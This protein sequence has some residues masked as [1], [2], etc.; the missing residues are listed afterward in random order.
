MGLIGRAVRAAAIVAGI[1]A[2]VDLWQIAFLNPA[3]LR[4][5][6]A[7]WLLFLHFATAFGAAVVPLFVLGRWRGGQA[8]YL[9]LPALIGCGVWLLLQEVGL[10]SL[11]PLSPWRLPVVV[12]ALAAGLAA[13]LVLARVRPRRWAWAASV[14]GLLLA[15]GLVGAVR[16]F[17]LPR[18]DES[19]PDAG[20][21]VTG[22]NVI[23]VLI[24]TLRA[25]H[26]SCYGYERP[27]SPAIDRFAT[28]GVLF[29]RAFSQSTWTKPA[30][31]SLFTGRY[32][33]QH[34]A[35]LE[36]ARLSDTELLLPEAFDQLGYRTAVFSGNPWITPD[37]GFDQGVDDFYS[38]Y[39]ERFARVTLFMMT[40]KRVSNLIDGGRSYNRVKMLVQ[41]ELST[42]ER[43]TRLNQEIDRWLDEHG[44]RPFFMHV[45]Y[46]SPHHPYD[47]PP[48]FDRFVPDP[49][50]EPVTYY[51]RKSYFFFEEGEEISEAQRAD[52]VARYDGDILFVDA[53]FDDLIANLRSRDLLD[54]TVVVLTSDHGEEFFDHRNWG[55]GQS[56][57]NELTHVPLIVRYP[58]RFPAG[59]RVDAPVMLVDVMPTVL[60]LAGASTPEGLAGRSLLALVAPRGTPE[61]R[62]AYSELLYRYGQAQALVQGDA[63]LV[64]MTKGE[65]SRTELYA[66]DEDF[67]ERHDLAEQAAA[68]RALEARLAAVE[69]WTR[70]HQGAAAAEVE[71]DAEMA[72]RLKALGYLQ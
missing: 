28:E 5:S 68:R 14:G 45:Q 20:A 40:L 46:M 26:L 62:E 25:D 53:V 65:Q 24:D 1:F 69:S 39:D 16:G 52:M 2:L 61:P 56:V 49:S 34:Q 19:G 37:Y 23:V 32:P 10:R 67:R 3:S 41:G 17:A 29:E 71:I 63:K 31:A 22:P 60:D 15:L 11:Q 9:V 58:E 6:G 66:L 47:P 70:E 43:D 8:P 38:V 30:T 44:R 42:T 4:P 27:T 55:H 72:N 50:L 12:G 57:Y 36:K 7:L 54:R 13:G 59:R 18:A 64:R 21:A 35:Y 48:P 33:S 51:P